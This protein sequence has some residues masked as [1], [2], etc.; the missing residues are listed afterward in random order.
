MASSSSP[1]AENTLRRVSLVVSPASPRTNSLRR[2]ESRS[3]TARTAS[4]TSEWRSDADWRRSRSC[5][6][7]NGRKILRMSSAARGAAGVTVA[8]GNAWEGGDDRESASPFSS[9]LRFFEKSMVRRRF[10]N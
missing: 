3:A 1:N 8:V 7:E 6:W 9:V 10:G 5:S 2:V 4:R